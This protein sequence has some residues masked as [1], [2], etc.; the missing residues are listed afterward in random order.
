MAD[1]LALQSARQNVI[2]TTGPAG[3]I[4]TGH[5]DDDD[6]S[7]SS[8][9]ESDS[10]SEKQGKSLSALTMKKS[11]PGL[12]MVAGQKVDIGVNVLIKGAG[13]YDYDVRAAKGRNRMFPF[14]PKRRRVD[15]YGEFVRAEDYIRA[16]ERGEDVL[17]GDDPEKEKKAPALVERVMGKKR[18][19]EDLSANKTPDVG[20]KK[21]GKILSGSDKES[22]EEEEEE[23]EVVEDTAEEDTDSEAE[24]ESQFSQPSKFISESTTITLNCH[25]TYIDFCGLHDSK[26][27]Q[28][29][30]P[31]IKPRKLIL[32]A[33][34]PR[35]TDHIAT[36]CRNLWVPKTP[37]AQR[38]VDVYTPAN[39]ETVNASV[40]TNAWVLRLSDQL[41]KQ[42]KWQNVGSL[43][44]SPALG[45]L[46][47]TPEEPVSANDADSHD[48]KRQ[49]L[50]LTPS[51]TA[52]IR[53]TSTDTDALT[54]I[55][56]DVP[57]ALMAAATRASHHP[58][59]VGDIKLPDLRKALQ[60]RGIQAEFRGPGQLLCD[61]AVMVQ[62][63]G[64][65]RLVVE[66]RGGGW[67]G[68][69]WK[70]VREVVYGGLAVVVGGN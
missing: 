36:Y 48:Q 1:R 29:L 28:N 25:I 64:T 68:G 34:T 14:L 7:S 32:I 69:L 3:I 55:T 5:E 44:V 70:R 12:P 6:V 2:Q 15:E 66:D 60:S 10:D 27:L 45:Q 67:R 52:I 11:A 41:V 8:D 20:K 43:S 16:E 58:I 13:I 46:R 24:L 49:K 17:D 61:G 50:D 37:K 22:G 19:W 35:E 39:G 57:P 56:L 30:L 51:S 53:P 4:T 62:K 54:P 21:K 42:L 38:E 40:D 59:L 63:D 9:D 65:G 47:I 31:K 18:K 33:G 23:G 26:T